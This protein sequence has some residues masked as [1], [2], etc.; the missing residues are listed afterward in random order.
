MGTVANEAKP[1]VAGPS[2]DGDG[3]DRAAGPGEPRA[4][5]AGR[6]EVDLAAP[7]GGGG[8]ALVYRGRDLRTRRPVAV[9][10][11]RLEYKQDPET[12]ARFRREARL[13]AFLAHPNVVRVFDFVEDRGATWVV[14]EQLSG[15]SLKD[16]VAERGPLPPDEVAAIL[17]QVAAA[18]GHLHGR[19]L[20]HLDV[21]P[22][23]LQLADDGRIKLID[24]GL[25]QPA[26]GIQQ[27]VGGRTFGTAAYLAP[28]QACGE[29]VEPATDIYALGCVVY[30]LLTGRPPF[31]D[32]RGTDRKNDV[33]R[34][35]LER[36][37]APPTKAGPDRTLPAWVDDVVLWALAREPS[38]RYA[39]AETF[40]RVF[41][42]A[43]DGERVVDIGTTGRV[44]AVDV[45]AS[46]Q[47]GKPTGAGSGP[48]GLSPW[49]NT[50]AARRSAR[51]RRG[52]WRAVVAVGVVDALLASALLLGQG[53]LPGVYEPDPPVLVSGAEARVV[54]Q[55]SRVR[56]A[57]GLAAT[58]LWALDEGERIEVTGEA[59]AGDD[60]RRWWPV[61]V[62]LDGGM[63]TGYMAEEGIAAERRTP[64]ER[65]AN[66]IGVG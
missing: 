60:G 11:L 66:A 28:E 2:G 45:P 12:R 46:W 14:L 30:E 33:V 52:L 41:R 63:A 15:R 49:G 3:A 17:D 34:A 54:I 39:S 23:N 29:A 37:P 1:P 42:A 51:L 8:M 59:V 16:L 44:A 21:K 47:D 13:L 56:E 57:P 32:G 9:K 61:A 10:T 4:T 55:D 53:E 65:L 62:E 5:I 38:A 35:R 22:Q 36:L 18:L 64:L 43:V 6:Y 40:A 26:G 27:T 7:I 48:T 19:G 50:A 31:G 20:V 25:A 58:A 24:F